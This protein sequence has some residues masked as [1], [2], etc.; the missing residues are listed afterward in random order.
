MTKTIENFLR[1]VTVD[2]QSQE[3]SDTIPSTMKQHDLAGLLVEELKAM[4]ACDITYDR[5]HC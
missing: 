1:Y 3:N 5:K 2:T 4:G